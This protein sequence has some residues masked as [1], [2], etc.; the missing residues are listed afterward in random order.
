[1]PPRGE[2]TKARLL[3]AAE[4]LF[5]ERGVDGVS[6]REINTAAQ[7]RNNVAL[8]YHFANRDGLILAIAQK[9][10][11][12]LDAR[13]D[14]LYAEAEADGMLH[15]FRTMVGVLWRPAAEYIGQGPSERAWLRIA[16]EL[17]ARPETARGDISNSASS[18][19]W[20]AGTVVVEQLHDDGLTLDFARQRVWASSEAVMHLIAGRARLEDARQPRR[21]VPPLDLFIADL[22]DT[23]CASLRAP[24]SHETRA[25]FEHTSSERRN[26][27]GDACA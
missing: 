14:E 10:M 21:P 2:V 17:G 4:K 9:H 15:D 24:M 23:T 11:P 16:A 18:T 5:A 12:R 22:V 26:R 6:L 8:Q 19:A 7:Q 20:K 1:V 13:Q 27:S 25:A 3:E